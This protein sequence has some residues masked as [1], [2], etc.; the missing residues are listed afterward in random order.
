MDRND[1]PVEAMQHEIVEQKV[2][3]RPKTR[4]EEDKKAQLRKASAKFYEKHTEKKKQDRRNL[5]NRQNGIPADRVRAQCIHIKRDGTQCPTTTF[6]QYCFNHTPKRAA[7][8][9]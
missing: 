9:P 6:N 5:Y 1:P 8:L 2:G 7:N 3:G 4:T